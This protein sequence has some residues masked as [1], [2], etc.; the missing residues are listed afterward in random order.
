M[1]CKGA[2]GYIERSIH[3][4]AAY[5]VCTYKHLH[6]SR[7]YIPSRTYS[8]YHVW[9]SISCVT[10]TED[11]P[12][13]R[14]L[15]PLQPILTLICVVLLPFLR[16]GTVDSMYCWQYVL[17][18]GTADS[19]YYWQYVLREGTVPSSIVSSMCW[20]NLNICL[21]MSSC[22]SYEDSHSVCLSLTLPVYSSRFLPRG[23]KHKNQNT[24]FTSIVA[25]G[26]C[27]LCCDNTVYNDL[28][29]GT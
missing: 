24:Y 7:M 11:K 16:E 22:F 26:R 13:P 20:G 18:E 14:Y 23:T 6:I 1:L 10:F 19:M 29:H 8:L 12:H 25:L 27:S 17:R 21:C 4:L 9:V 15:S 2:R 28:H 3:P 5:T